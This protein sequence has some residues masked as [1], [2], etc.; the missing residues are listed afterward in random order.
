MNNNSNEHVLVG[1]SSSP[2][3]EK[4]V[5]TAA[6]MAKAF[7][8]KFTALYVKTSNADKM[9]LEDKERLKINIT[10]AESLGATVVTIYG[11]DI[12]FQIAEYARISDVTKIVVGRSSVNKRKSPIKSLV[13][14]QLI[15]IAPNVDIY[16]IPDHNLKTLQK[17]NFFNTS[18]TLKE[19]L[20]SFAIMFLTTLLGQIFMQLG[21]TDANIVTIYILSV[22]LTS[23][24]TNSK[25]CWILSSFLSVF[26]FNF[27]FTDPKYSFIAYDKGYI[28]TFAVMLTASLVTGNIANKMKIQAKESAEIAYRT[29]ILFDTNKKLQKVS[30]NNE[31]IQVTIEQLQNLLRRNI[32]GYLSENGYINDGGKFDS[33]AIKYALDNN[34]IVGLDTKYKSKDEFIY[35]PISL[36]SNIYGIIIIENNKTMIDSFDNRIL[37]SIIGECAISLENNYILQEKEK[38]ETL[39]KNEKLRSNLLRA[40]SHDLRTPLTTIAGNADTLLINSDSFDEETKRQMYAIIY[41]DAMWLHNLVE[42]ILSI[43]KIEDGEMNFNYTTELINDVVVEALKHIERRKIKNTINFNANADMVFV[44]IDARLIIQV[45]INLLDNA[46]KYSKENSTITIETKLEDNT[47]YVIVSDY[48]IGIPDDIKPYIFDRFYIG[49]NTVIDGRKSLGLGLSLCKSIIKAH[50]GEIFVL[51][52]EPCGTKVIFTLPIEEV[53]I[54]E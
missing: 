18:L 35:M 44:K 41:E 6:K 37:L 51:D 2:S 46:I 29:K 9:S 20:I 54:H 5:K 53:D 27:F 23:I 24:L 28:M 34:V 52:N 47:L 8:A 43:T 1:L 13:T 33:E 45:I 38:T 12:S 22:L 42:N 19:L 7:N 32:Y 36:N 49:T 39:A 4:I 48:G 40:I 26:V 11:D 30:S 50:D 3:N 17:Q 21:F 25:V 16:I 31:I 14:D 10:F 15:S